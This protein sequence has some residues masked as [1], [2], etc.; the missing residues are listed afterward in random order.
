MLIL[1]NFKLNLSIYP[2]TVIKKAV[3]DY[4]N[5]IKVEY[6]INRR[7]N[8]IDIIF[9]DLDNDFELYKLEFCNYLIALIAVW[10]I[11]LI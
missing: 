10:T 4:Q 7:Q 2:L 1:N 5:I 8:Y 11:F 3:K 9:Y 6:E